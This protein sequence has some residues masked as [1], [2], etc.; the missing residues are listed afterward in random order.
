MPLTW[1][2]FAGLVMATVGAAGS[3][4]PDQRCTH[5]ALDL[6]RGRARL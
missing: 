6:G 4:R 1:A 5:V 3:S 2:S